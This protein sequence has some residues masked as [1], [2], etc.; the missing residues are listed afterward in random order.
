MRSTYTD[1]ARHFS[2]RLAPWQDTQI[3][4]P[5]TQPGE[6]PSS[7]L[8]LPPTGGYLTIPFNMGHRQ[9]HGLFEKNR[10]R[11]L[12][13]TEPDCKKPRKIGH[14]CMLRGLDI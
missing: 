7:E 4:S 8:G 6:S 5:P 11:E 2:G 14:S 9:K 13:K 1:E 3:Q 10:G 12:R